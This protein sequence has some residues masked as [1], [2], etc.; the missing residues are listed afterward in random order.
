[1]TINKGKRPP[2]LKLSPKS[3]SSAIENAVYANKCLWE[4]YQIKLSYDSV[5]SCLIKLGMTAKTKIKK[6]LLTHVYR[7]KRLKFAKDHINPIV[8]TVLPRI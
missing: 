1:M 7:M 2:K 5:R 8:T 3:R 4:S 6:S